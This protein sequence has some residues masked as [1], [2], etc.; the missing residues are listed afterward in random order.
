MKAAMTL[1]FA[2]FL[3]CGEFTIARNAAFNPAIH[4][5]RSSV[6]FIPD[7]DNATHIRLSL[8]ASKTD[9][10]RRGVTLL[11]AAAPGAITCPVAALREIYKGDPWA[12]GAPLFS[13]LEPR[14]ALSRDMFISHLKALLAS[15]GLDSTR[16]SG[17]SFR[18]GAATSAAV[19]G[20]S[21]NEIQ[22]LGRWR[23]DAYRLY[24]DLPRDRILHLSSR[25]H[26]AEAEPHAQPFEPPALPFAPTMA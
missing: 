22:Q 12:E 20:Y 10:F 7:M 26:W 15:L 2:G 18:R 4:L 14:T 5:T 17:H 23:S 3:R 19:A 8:P 25:L 11:L 16:Y 24:I 9:P 21:D 1:A 13:G 6:E